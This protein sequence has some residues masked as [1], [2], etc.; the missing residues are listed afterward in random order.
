M[1]VIDIL[2]N[3]MNNDKELF[4]STDFIKASI[5]ILALKIMEGECFI[6][7]FGI[8]SQE[9]CSYCEYFLEIHQT[10]LLRFFTNHFYKILGIRI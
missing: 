9:K 3:F 5:E 6:V 2:F 4:L 1:L 7:L 8:E 10:R